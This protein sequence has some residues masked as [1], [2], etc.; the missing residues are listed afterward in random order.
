MMHG[1]HAGSTVVILNQ[2]TVSHVGR[3]CLRLG[4]GEN[5]SYGEAWGVG[6]PMILMC[7]GFCFGLISRYQDPTTTVDG[8]EIWRSPVEVGSLSHYL[9]GCIHFR[10][11]RISSINSINQLKQR[12][13]NSHFQKIPQRHVLKE[14]CPPCK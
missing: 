10:W 8:S 9:Q 5:G 1:S 13:N 11:C 3:D 4:G 6:D 14:D 7:L 12:R 2:K